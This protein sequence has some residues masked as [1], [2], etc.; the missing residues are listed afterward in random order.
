MRNDLNVPDS[1]WGTLLKLLMP[2][3]LASG[4]ATADQL[5]DQ[6]HSIENFYDKSKTAKREESKDAD[7]GLAQKT[8]NEFQQQDLDLP[9]EMTFFRIENDHRINL[10]AHADYRFTW[11]H[12]QEESDALNLKAKGL[13]KIGT[14]WRFAIYGQDLFQ[15]EFADPEDQESKDFPIRITRLLGGLGKHFATSDEDFMVYVEPQLGYEHID[16]RG[17][18][19]LWADTMR[20]GLKAG[21]ASRSLDALAMLN[22]SASPSVFGVRGVDQHKGKVGVDEIPVEGEMQRAT[23]TVH[24]MK[25]LGRNVYIF[26]KAGADYKN[27]ENYVKLNT[28]MVSAGAQGRISVA[29]MPLALSAELYAKRNLRDFIRN[30]VEERNVYGMALQAMLKIRQGIY[31]GAGYKCERPQDLEWGSERHHGWGHTE[32]E[33]RA[34]LR[35]I[36]GD[37]VDNIRGKKKD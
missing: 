5:A 22:V 33:A 4:C 27:F 18:V 8:Q 31:V 19:D 26:A 7:S 21:A 6:K 29:G 15:T 24:V 13:L 36:P 23:G 16:F 2:V 30:P 3:A 1:Y 28:Y 17:P 14:D 37:I 9:D 32:H 10:L 35:L 12:G 25:G 11:E 20:F 34:M